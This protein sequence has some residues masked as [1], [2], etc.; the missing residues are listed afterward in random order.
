MPPYGLER[1]R[2]AAADV[3]V[4]IE[5]LDPFLLSDS[6]VSLA[7]DAARRFQ[8]DLIGLGLRVVDDCIVVARPEDP[9]EGPFDIAWFAPE[10]RELRDAL[11]RAAPEACFVLGGAAFSA[12]PQECLDYF[13]VEFGIVG[14]GEEAFQALLVGLARGADP[15]TIPGVVK[16]GADASPGAYVHA[17]GGPTRRDPL[18]APL[19]SFPVRTRIGCAMQCAYCLTANLGRTHSVAARDAVLAE[20]EATI[21]HAHEHGVGQ[22]PLFFADDELNLPSEDHVLGVLGGLLERGLTPKLK[23]RAYFNPTPFSDELARLVAATNGHA[24]VTVDTAAEPVMVRVQKPFRRRHLDHLIPRLVEHG[25][26]CDVGLIFGLPGETDETIAE[27]ADWVRSLP[28]QIRVSYSA[29]ARVYPHTP[30]A[31]I[32]REEP[33]RL[34]GSQDPTFFEP[35]VYSSPYPPRRL[36]AMLSR[37]FRELP[38]VHPVSVGYRVARR[39]DAPAYRL[40]LGGG[41]RQAWAELLD[42]AKEEAHDGRTP[43]ER[44]LGCIHLALWHSRFDLAAPACRRLL[45]NGSELPR[46]ASRGQ[47]RAIWGLCLVLAGTGHMRRALGGRRSSPDLAHQR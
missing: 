36:A 17:S 16:R 21:E 46:D 43:S 37:T 41:G 25:V 18:Y 2:T 34:I 1:L 4:D 8:P 12:F 10:I 40:A 9:G 44:L 23:W 30:L 6:P 7:A 39:F 33:H 32:A 19:V 38:N 28:A 27:T 14:A 24:S 47:L 5:L 42:E 3:D 29:G 15:E 31:R 35:V 20:I 11:G 26:S 13:D 22:T 45:R